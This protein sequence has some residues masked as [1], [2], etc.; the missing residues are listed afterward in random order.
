MFAVL[1]WQ[2]RRRS[3]FASAVLYDEPDYAGSTMISIL[4]G[5][6]VVPRQDLECLEDA[7]TLLEDEIAVA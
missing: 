7:G 6:Q 2:C 3:G 4:N 5:S 1:P